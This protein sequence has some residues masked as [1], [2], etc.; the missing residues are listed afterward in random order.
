M[1]SRRGPRQEMPGCSSTIRNGRNIRDCRAAA[2][3]AGGRGLCSGWAATTWPRCGPPPRPTARCPAAA[4]SQ[5]VHLHLPVRRAGPARQLRPE[6]RRPRRHPR[7][8][9]ARSPRARPASRS[10]NTCRCWPQ[11]SHL[12]ALVRS[13]THPSQR[14]LGRPPAS[15]SPAAR[16]L[17]PGFNAEHAASRATG[18]RSPPSPATLTRPQQQPAAGGR[19]ARAA[20]PQH[21]PRHS[22]P[23][24]RRRWGRAAIRGSSRRRR[25]DP[26]GLRRLSRVRVRPPAAPARPTT[27]AFQAPNLTLPEGLDGDRFGDRLDLLE[28]HRPPAA[29]P[30]AR[31]PTDE[32][33][34]PPPERPSRC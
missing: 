21:G 28:R 12:W 30:R 26:H 17:P 34:P 31:R 15:C 25:F 9:Q 8:V 23:V 7:R 24:R 18:R 6:A 10:A 1:L 5:G 29:A 16:E 2:I 32:L 4:E 22:R 27:A 3:Q 19:A 11:R 13:L 20:G 14:P 33:R